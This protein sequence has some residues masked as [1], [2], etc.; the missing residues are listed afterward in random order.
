MKFV[1]SNLHASAMASEIFPQI[2]KSQD[3]SGVKKTCF[4]PSRTPPDQKRRILLKHGPNL[5]LICINSC[6][7]NDARPRM[8]RH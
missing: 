7:E 3:K 8:L 5:S 2:E 6:I 1:F 4:F